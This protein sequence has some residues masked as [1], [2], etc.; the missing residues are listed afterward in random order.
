MVAAL[1]GRKY[2]ISRAS[3]FHAFGFF[4]DGFTA[5]T[6]CAAALN[7]VCSLLRHVVERFQ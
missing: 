6:V 7:L 4:C 3:S 1:Y 2:G 5:L